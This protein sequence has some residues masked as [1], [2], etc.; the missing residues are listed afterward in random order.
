M[1]IAP[2]PRSRLVRPNLFA[3]IVGVKQL[4]ARFVRKSSAS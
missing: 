3:R 2:R 1:A 4:T